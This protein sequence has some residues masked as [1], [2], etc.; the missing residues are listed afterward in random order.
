M[1]SNGLGVKKIMARLRKDK[2]FSAAE[3]VYIELGYDEEMYETIIAN[4]YTKGK[5]DALREWEPQYKINR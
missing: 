5:I 4:A 1:I 3:R 2:Y